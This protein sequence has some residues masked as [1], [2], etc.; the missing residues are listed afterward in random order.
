[1]RIISIVFCLLM[2][3]SPV[4]L[5]Q[6]E[7]NFVSVPVTVSDR[8]GRYISGLKKE[9][10]KILEGDAEQKVSFFA[11]EDEPI[12][13]ALLLDTSEST[14]D[15]L[16]KIRDAAKDFVG[17]L[18]ENDQCLVATF[19]SEVKVLSPFTS[20]HGDLKKSL[21]KIQTADREGTVVFNAV[22]QITRDYFVKVK[23]RK[24]IV[25]LSDG[26]DYRSSITKNELLSH[27]EES[28]VLIYS[29]FYQTGKGFEKVVVDA[30]GAVKEGAKPQKT[31]KPKESE[32][33]QK[34]KKKKQYTIQLGLPRDTYTPD[35]IKLS[36][37]LASVEA[38]GILQEMSDTT[39][40]RFYLSDTPNL[41]RVFK[42]IAAELREQYRLGF[43]TKTASDEAVNN[44]IVKVSR[45][46]AV[47]RA[48]GKYRAKNL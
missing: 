31:E 3:I 44:I 36:D 29:I 23:G 8:Q 10:F 20:D 22:E 1:M 21:D 6:S 33:T 12:S 19:D 30:D 14:K 34:P 9:D 42:E 4:V 46:D 40:G 24:V 13:V 47:V 25:L 48:R 38:I 27:L 37:K 7:K 5:G 11:T 16:D 41:S 17:L 2:V 15:V 26:K 45:P 28:D 39:A 18:N 32:K 43:Y 35:E